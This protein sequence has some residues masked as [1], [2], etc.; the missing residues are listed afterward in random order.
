MDEYEPQGFRLKIPKTSARFHPISDVV[1]L[2]LK[3]QTA[4]VLSISYEKC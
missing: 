4:S 1:Y 2:F 3:L